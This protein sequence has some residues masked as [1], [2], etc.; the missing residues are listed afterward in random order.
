[1]TRSDFDRD[2]TSTKKIENMF[3]ELSKESV[4]AVVLLRVRRVWK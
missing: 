4:L 3:K 2:L 1:M